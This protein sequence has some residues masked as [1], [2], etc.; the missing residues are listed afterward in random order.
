MS[1]VSGVK[2]DTG[3]IHYTVSGDE[4]MRRARTRARNILG[5]LPRFGGP[6]DALPRCGRRSTPRSGYRLV[7]L[8]AMA[9][10]GMM[11]GAAD[12]VLVDRSEVPRSI[13]RQSLEQSK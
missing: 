7:A 10:V 8:V 11:C 4:G 5:V 3:W 6:A 1:T 2:L 9:L 12:D 13:S